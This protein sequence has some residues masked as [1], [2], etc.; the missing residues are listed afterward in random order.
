RLLSAMAESRA[1]IFIVSPCLGV[2][3][4][5]IRSRDRTFAGFAHDIHTWRILRIQRDRGGRAHR[6][7]RLGDGRYWAVI[8]GCSGIDRGPMVQSRT[9]RDR[10]SLLGGPQG[11]ERLPRLV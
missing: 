11:K 5:A 4:R 10:R 2:D 7:D 9:A 3:C 6:A 1:E 8:D